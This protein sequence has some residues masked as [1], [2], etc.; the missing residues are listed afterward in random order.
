M[1]L[2]VAVCNL[3]PARGTPKAAILDGDST[4]VR[5]DFPPALG[6]SFVLLEVGV[7][8]PRRDEV[9][10]L[11]VTTLTFGDCV[12]EPKGARSFEAM[13]DLAALLA[14]VRDRDRCFACLP[15]NNGSLPSPVAVMRH[16]PTIAR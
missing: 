6:A 7:E 3:I 2:I 9:E 10:Y 8:V 4:Y 15:C 14:G 16:A 1:L 11:R 13:G 12:P 5:C